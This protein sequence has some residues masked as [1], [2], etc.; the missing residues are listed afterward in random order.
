VKKIAQNVTQP[1][2]VK[3]IPWRKKYTIWQPWFQSQKIGS[4][5]K[6]R[7]LP[8]LSRVARFFLIQHTKTGKI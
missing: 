6:W 8:E 2:F 7:S 3:L 1:I 4:Q 5:A